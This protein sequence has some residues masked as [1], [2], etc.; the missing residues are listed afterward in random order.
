MR[1]AILTILMLAYAL[2]AISSADTITFNGGDSSIVLRNGR[3]RV[4]LSSG[5]SVSVGSLTISA[6]T[7]TL[8]GD[9]WSRV[10]CSGN[11][12]ITDD[13]RGI[14]IRTS[15]VFYDRNEERI[16]ISSWFE[17]DDTVNAVSAT[18]AYLEYRLNDEHLQLDKS[19]TLMKD[20]DRGIM[21]CMA[22]S[23]VFSRGDNTLEL[24]GDAQVYWDGNEYG[25]EVIRVD[26]NTDSITLEGRIRG[27]I[28]G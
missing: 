6:D 15:T 13:E 19:V 26:L 11:A 4:V 20:T 10:E 25:A 14:S 28:N 12:S 1:K 23:V 2:A 7:I 16:L 22:E 27:N 9:G 5:A 18:G 17:V 8:S 24:R 3:E 21:R